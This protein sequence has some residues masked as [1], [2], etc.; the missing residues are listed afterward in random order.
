MRTT[1]SF[2]PR[3]AFDSTSSEPRSGRR[4]VAWSIGLALL[5]VV[6][7]AIVRTRWPTPPPPPAEPV[8]YLEHPEFEPFWVL[9]RHEDIK[10][11]SQNNDKFI[12]NPRTVILPREFEQMLLEQF[13]TPNGLETLIHMDNPKHRL[14]VFDERD[15]DGEFAVA[16]DEL[17]GAI[18]GVHNP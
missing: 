4:R 8:A 6:G 14:M 3:T 5:V 7:T 13:G 17:L 2:P 15:I 12:N 9:T 11:V 1:Q 18:D 10:Y 16:L